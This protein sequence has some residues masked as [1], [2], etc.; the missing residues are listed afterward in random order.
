MTSEQFT[1]SFSEEV[2]TTTYKDSKDHCVEDTWLRN[3]SAIASVEVE[4][5][6]AEWT[7]RFYEMLQGFH[8]CPGGRIL[9]NAGAGWKATT[10]F[11]CFTAPCHDYDIDSLGGI[12]QAVSD[13]VHI[14]RSEGGFGS[15]FSYIRPRGAFV[16][17]IGV[18][19]PGAVKYAEIFDK[20]SDVITAGSGQKIKEK[21]AKGKTRRGAMMGIL[22]VWHPDIEEF[23][24]AKLTPGRLTKFNL[25]VGMY[26]HFMKKVAAI[27]E[28]ESKGE[29]VTDEMDRWDLIFPVTTHPLYKEKWRGQIY[30]WI[31][32]G[33]PVKVYKTVSIRYLWNLIME[34]TYNRNDPGV[35]FFDTANRT[36]LWN[37]GGPKSFI[38]ATNP[39]AEESMPDGSAC[40]LGSINCTK[41][42][43]MKTRRFNLDLV[44]K[45]AKTAVR[46]L[47]N[48]IDYSPL[49]L[50]ILEERVRGKRRIGLG[51]LGFASAL[52]LMKVRFA[53]DEAERIKEEFARAFTHAAVEAS[54]DLAEEKG[55]F[56]E[57]D[58]DKV[59]DHIFWKQIDLPQHLIDRMRRVGI[60]NSAL[61]S[62]QPTG[63]TSILCNVVSGGLEPIFLHEYVRTSILHEI[64]DHIKHVCPNYPAG[65]FIETD[66]FKWVKE[67][68]DEIL[69]GVDAEG[70]VYKIDRNRGLT[71]ETL[72]EDYAVRIL[73]DLG[74]WDANAD[75]AVT[76][77][78]LTA[79]EHIRDLEGWARWID[80]AMSKTINLPNSYPYE[81]FKKI[82]L[83][84]WR[85][86]TIKGVTTYRDGT[87]MNVLAAAGSKPKPTSIAKHDAPKRPNV[88]PADIHA[89]TH[90][91]QK[92]YVA[93]GLLEG[94]PYEVFAGSNHTI[95]KG[96]GTIKKVARGA[97]R[98]EGDDGALIENLAEGCHDDEEALARILSAALRHGS[99]IEFLTDQLEKTKG[100]MNSFAKVIARTL[101]KY[102][103]EGTVVSGAACPE[104]DGSL[105]R[106]SGCQT[107]KSC[108]WSKCG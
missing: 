27:E 79:A 23:I 56:V 15:N 58:F 39:C 18:E 51:V 106:E 91:G 92:Y 11:N 90:K 83:N 102:V 42:V 59:A 31:E 3:A 62:I 66:M 100:H 9:S 46:F 7:D 6:R 77:A 28:A 64:P 30:H 5:K 76:T 1:N 53:S 87:M 54:I 33:L 48:V 107:C 95:K 96:S 22:D 16:G 75:W 93:V 101:K 50:P 103:K 60:R 97:Y 85:T 38:R 24:R 98:F 17:G 47:D 63:N 8:V 82:Y 68:T 35:L 86:G 37:F 70:V 29:P 40:D 61:F 34:S 71:R 32:E 14:L 25:S 78:N 52:Y 72:C 2:W 44:R 21:G 81:D 105:V 36:H 43:D 13:Q 19:T 41:F 99:Q 10:L 104:C 94:E 26:D 49:P 74:E 4:K 89:V 108:G 20:T 45:Y 65:E 84:A 88:L 57:C 55:A 73:K 80:A 69:R 12:M 67:G